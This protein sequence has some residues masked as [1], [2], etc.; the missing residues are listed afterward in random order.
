MGN[1]SSIPP[2]IN[3]DLMFFN[4]KAPTQTQKLKTLQ[5]LILSYFHNIIHMLS[6]LTDKEMLQL[7]VTESAKLIPY[8]ISSRKA[9]KLYLKVCA[10]I[11]PCTSYSLLTTFF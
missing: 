2:L 10:R 4:S 9:V 7:A 8:I 1:C 3:L 6:Q 5:K 11:T